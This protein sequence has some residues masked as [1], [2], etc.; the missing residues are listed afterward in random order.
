MGSTPLTRST[1]FDI[2]GAM[3]L[4]ENFYRK[5]ESTA[6]GEEEKL[7]RDLAKLE[8][9]LEDFRAGRLAWRGEKYFAMNNEAA[10]IRRKLNA[11]TKPPAETE[12]GS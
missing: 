7:R 3:N 6:E 11:L 1:V 2:I 8:K 10:E 12:E 9:E 4:F 5:K